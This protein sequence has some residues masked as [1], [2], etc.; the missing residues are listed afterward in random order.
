LDSQIVKN[1]KVSEFKCKCGC[2][3][4]KLD[5]NLATKLQQIRNTI[6]A[7]TIE[8]AYRCPKHNA[9]LKGSSPKSLHLNGN[10]ADITTNKSPYEV[11]RIAY[12][13]GF[14]GIGVANNAN[15]K[16]VHI[17][18]RDSFSFWYYDLNNNA[19]ALTLTEFKKLIGL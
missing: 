7:I 6:G 14:K 2:D 16:Y 15:H 19:H 1:F 13:N 5:I 17:D 4:V 18:T 12:I 9:Q 10:A 8:S 3:T 11:A